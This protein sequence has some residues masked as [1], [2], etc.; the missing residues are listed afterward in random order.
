LSINAPNILFY[1]PVHLSALT[2]TITD[3]AGST[4]IFGGE[5][6]TRHGQTY[7]ASVVLTGNPVDLFATTTL[8]GDSITLASIGA[9]NHPLTI[10]SAIPISAATIF[11]GLGGLHELHYVPFNPSTADS[12]LPPDY[13]SGPLPPKAVGQ[14]SDPTG[15]SSIVAEFDIGTSL[16][17]TGDLEFDDKARLMA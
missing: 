10:S 16:I 14:I 7:N 6:K 8:L 5:V 4:Q 3:P 11:N 12:D 2:A 1:G 13:T 15:S 17:S 9:N